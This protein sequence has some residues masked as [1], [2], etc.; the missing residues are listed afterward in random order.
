MPPRDA[1]P[2]IIRIVEG[3]RGEVRVHS[4]IN[5]AFNLSEDIGP[6]EHRKSE[7]RAGRAGQRG[8]DESLSRVAAQALGSPIL[9]R[10]TTGR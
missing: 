9:S 7:R 10:A 8:R 1:S 6:A 5:T 3:V 4:L 2:G